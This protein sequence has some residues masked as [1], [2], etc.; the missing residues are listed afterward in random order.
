MSRNP[1]GDDEPLRPERV[2][3]FGEEPELPS[4]EAAAGRIEQATRRVRSLRAQLGAEGLTPSATRELIDE[5]ATAL[6]ATAGA[7]RTRQDG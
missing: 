4:P 5:L 3:P 6:E 7:L 1:F 2:N